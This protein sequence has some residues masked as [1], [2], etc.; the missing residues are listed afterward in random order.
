MLKV[1]R[2]RWFR[3]SLASAGLFALLLGVAMISACTAMGGRATG[4]RRAAMEQSAQWKG[5]RFGNPLA[6]KDGPYID[7]LVQWVKGAKNTSPSAPMPVLDRTAAEFSDAPAADALNI[8]WLG[9]STLLVELDGLRVLIDPV[10]GERV[11]PFRFAGPK[12]FHAPPLAFDD[13]PS[14]DAV[15]ISHDHYDH[16]DYPTIVALKDRAKRFVVPLGVGAHLAYWGVDEAKITELDWWGSL[17]C[18]G[19]ELIATPARH[20]SG[21][22]VVMSDQDQTL[23]AGWIVKGPTHRIFYSGDTAMHPTFSEIGERY[24]PFDATLMESGAYNAL[25]A[26]VHMG[27]EQAVKAHKMVKGKLLIPVHWGTFDLAIH[28]WT[29]P[30]ER[31]LVAAEAAGVQAVVPQPGET[32]FPDA[33]RALT[34]WWPELDWQTAQQAPVI[35]SGLGIRQPGE[36]S[37]LPPS[38]EQDARSADYARVMREP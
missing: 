37:G 21:R 15:V 23:W 1:F 28:A 20:F 17:D 29:E 10:W 3:I 5:E 34:R 6:R 11:S 14:I 38:A 13:L 27:P 35:S 36:H 26:D 25:W 33:P 9:H 2:S 22:S 12:R 24:G 4:A 18:G 16:L 31:L 32:V 30:V 7:M 19:V 8:T